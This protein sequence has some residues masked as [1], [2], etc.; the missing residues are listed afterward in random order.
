MRRESQEP[1]DY[2]NGKNP[3]YHT[4]LSSDNPTLNAVKFENDKTVLLSSIDT[5]YNAIEDIYLLLGVKPENLSSI[6]HTG[7][8]PMHMMNTTPITKLSV[9][10]IQTIFERDIEDPELDITLLPV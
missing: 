5:L 1:Y 3:D 9:E 7:S 10:S 8:T 6:M 4:A 2:T